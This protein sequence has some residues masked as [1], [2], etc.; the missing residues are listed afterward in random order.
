MVRRA[1]L[2][3]TFL[4]LAALGAVWASMPL[5]N[6]PEGHHRMGNAA[7]IR[8]CYPCRLIDPNALG[9]SVGSDNR[10]IGIQ[11]WVF[12]EAKARVSAV[13]GSA[14]CCVVLALLVL[15]LGD[16]R[17]AASSAQTSSG[18][19]P[20]RPYF[21]LSVCLIVLAPLLATAFA[22]IIKARN[23]TA[24]N[25]AIDDLEMPTTEFTVPDG[26]RGRTPSVP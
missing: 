10:G 2:T 9:K 4:G 5:L 17:R 25:Y 23:T 24:Y 15:R 19:A 13:L 26:A 20:E 8:D 14:V 1:I 21:W 3:F 18:G 6:P 7:L 11:E 12:T 16:R 22:S